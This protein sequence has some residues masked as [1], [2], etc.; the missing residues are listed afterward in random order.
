MKRV[1]PW[2]GQI[3]LYGLFALVIGVFA[4]GPGY[5]ALPPGQAL[6][7]VSFIH[8]GQR[9]ADCRPYTAEELAKLAPNMRTPLKCG[10]ERSPVTIEVD[11]DGATVYRH[12]APPSGLSSDGASTVYH[13]L[14]VAAGEHRIAVRLKDSAGPAFTHTREA[15]LTL[16]PAQVL[17]I[18]FDDQKGEI[19]LS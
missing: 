7:K 2:A 9:V 8:H 11:L 12:V 16:K 19:T 10:R 3:L 5:R 14:Q 6:V 1:A 15:T 18:D 4:N 17:V 13:R